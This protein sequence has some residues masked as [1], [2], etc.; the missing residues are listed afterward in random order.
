MKSAVAYPVVVT[1][2]ATWK[3]ASR[4]A[5]PIPDVTEEMSA[6]MIPID[7]ATMPRYIQSSSD[8]K[9]ERNRFISSRKYRLKFTPKSSMNTVTTPCT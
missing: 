6:V 5:S 2:E 3:D 7:T 1:M 8:R 4:K 9:A